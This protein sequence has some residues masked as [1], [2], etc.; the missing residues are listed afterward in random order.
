[1]AA[2]QFEEY[3]DILYFYGFADGD[4]AAARR[5]Y[6]RRFPNRRLPDVSVFGETYRRIRESG[7]VQRRQANAGRP[8]VRNPVQEEEILEL[9]RADGTIS[10]REVAHQLGM[11]QWKVWFTLHSSRLY[12]YHYTP[13]HAIEEGDPRRRLDFCRFL[14]NADIEDPEY[15]KKILWT[16]ESNFDRDGITNYHNLH[17]WAPKGQNPR[18]SNEGAHQHRFSLNVWMGIMHDKLIGPFFLPARLNGIAYG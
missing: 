1:M 5:E 18:K 11:S 7:S 10:T 6:Q 2:Y 14:V 13:V 3:A 15:L 16:D 12:P 4:A 9:F 8:Q 17:F